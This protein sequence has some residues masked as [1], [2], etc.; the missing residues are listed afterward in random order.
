MDREENIRKL[1][2]ETNHAIEQ[3]KVSRIMNFVIRTIDI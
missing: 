3:T 1:I 2:W